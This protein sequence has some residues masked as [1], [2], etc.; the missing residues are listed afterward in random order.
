[1][2]CARPDPVASEYTQY[3]NAWGIQ[4]F[5]GRTVLGGRGSDAQPLPT[6]ANASRVFMFMVRETMTGPGTA[7]RTRRQHLRVSVRRVHI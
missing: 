1:M 3:H 4:L 2:P 7:G 6:E 5:P